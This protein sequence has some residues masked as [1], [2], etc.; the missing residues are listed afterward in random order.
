MSNESDQDQGYGAQAD[1]PGEPV[2]APRAGLGRR[3]R[4]LVPA[5]VAAVV[6]AGVV[7]V[8]ALA[9]SQDL[10]SVTA[11]QLL[12]KMLSSKVQTFS[13]NVTATVDLGLPAGLSGL[14]PSGAAGAGVGGSAG[15]AK[16]DPSQAAAEQQLIALLSGGK[17]SFQIAADGQDRQRVSSAD[18]GTAFTAVHNGG[19]AWIYDAQGNTATHLTGIDAGA[20]GADSPLSNPQQVAAQALKALG[21]STSVSVA[22]TSKVAGQSVYE[23]S[24]KPKGSGSTVGEVRIAVDAANGMPLQVR[25]NPADGSDSILNVSFTHVSFATP[26]ASTFAFTPPSG[27]KVTEQAAPSHS[28]ATA[29]GDKGQQGI[30]GE[31][32]AK[33]GNS[34]IGSNEKTIGTGWSTIYSFAPATGGGKAGSPASDISGLKALGKQVPGG[35]LISTKLV[36]VLITDKGTVYAGAV[37]PALLQQAAG[38]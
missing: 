22:G 37:T 3:R 21:P 35:T 16:A 18:A 32:G 13:G 14:L 34:D 33:T 31:K 23:L 7:A 20:A 25:V 28:A 5:A 30:L 11:Q 27:A 2:A 10:P 9:A 15:S 19:S 12:T 26:A 6:A 38:K 8:P 29:K 36:N 1:R 24:V 17:H 4:V